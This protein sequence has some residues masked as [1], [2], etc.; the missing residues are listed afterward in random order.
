[1]KKKCYSAIFRKMQLGVLILYL[2]HAVGFAQTGVPITIKGK[3]TERNG[4]STVPGTSIK[5]KG[6]QGGTSSDANGNYSLTTKPGDILVFSSIGYESQEIAVTRQTTVNI[7]FIP[8]TEGLDEVVVVGFG[9]QKKVNLTG[10]V[11]S[12]SSKDLIVRPVGQASAALQGLAAGVTVT[13]SSGQPGADAG[14]IRIRGIGTLLDA[15]PL[16]LID[17]VEG[18]INALDPNIIENVSVLKD[19]ASASIYG[20]R[21]ANGVILV[22]TKRAKNNQL[23]VN[24]NGY[25]GFQD[26][27]NLPKMVNAIDH[28]VLTN[29]A[30]TNTGKAPLYSDALIQAYRDNPGNTDLYPNT[31]WQKEVLTGS[32]FMQSHFISIN[33]GGEKI[34]FLTSAG[35]FD[36][37]GII[38]NSG[39]RRFT[40]RNNADV[41]FSDKL[42]LKVDLQLLAANSL[43]PGP[44]TSAVFH[45]MNRIPANQAFRYSNGNWGEGWNGSNPVA[46]TT[47]DGGFQKNSSPSAQLNATLTYQPLKWLKADLTAAP[48]YSQ[49]EDNN[50]NRAVVTYKQDGTVAYTAPALSTLTRSLSHSYYNNYRATVTADQ[51]V[52]DH[53]FKVLVGASRED[54]RNDG[55]SAFRDNFVLPDYPVLNT[56]S[57]ANQQ[58]TGSAAEWALQSFFGRINYDYKQKYLLEINGRYDGSSRFAE[59]HKYGFFPSVSA[60]WRI[61]QESFMQPVKDVINDLKIRA[62]W[63][64]L[65]N[66]NI[67]NYPFTSSIASGSYTIG[68]QIVNIAALNTL[69]NSGISWETTAMTDFGLDFTI[70]KNLSFTGD[71]YIRRS[72]DILYTLDIPLTVGLAAPIQNVGVVTNK[73]Y[74]L[75][76]SYRNNI[77]DFKYDISV[78]F[79]DVINRVVDLRGV[80]RSALTVSREGSSINS[81]FGLQA[82]G[83]FQ[84]DAEAAAHATQF[85]ITKAGDIKY[86]DQNGDGVIN[87]ADNVIIGST[88][89]RYTYS[90]S[91]NASYK[92]FSIAAFFQ[93]VGKADGFLYQQ[94]IMPFFNGGTV[95]EQHKDNWTPTNTGAAFPRLAFSETNNEKVSSFWVKDASYLRLKNLQ[96][97][98]SLPARIA[99][100]LSTSSIRVFVNGQNLFTKDHFWKGYDVEAPVGRGDVYP[101]VKT[102]TVGL[103]VNF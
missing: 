72:R 11:S 31:D 51:A 58:T 67:G 23:S 100:K 98:Y 17:G 30:Y 48:R 8:S 18:S 33:G 55:F 74:E 40:L 76:L 86:K 52:G 6:Q 59:G 10:A 65:G 87:D 16:V 66:Q 3:I 82:E 61:S 35:F 79:S 50:F 25:S 53:T 34:R 19:A 73:G 101:Q 44:G 91:L 38:E 89:P 56:G 95:Q 28:M 1:M 70:L 88:I 68:K 102:Y 7:S 29:L 15:N 78:N 41:R 77:R 14:N 103:D 36:Q 62:S 84:S 12:I 13:Q 2:I 99:S 60:G 90:A 54:Y 69:A 43:E 27:T 5:I 37:K 85:G 63:G 92:G 20:S 83:L 49:S 93:G 94:G 46:F 45:W 75:A 57:S 64:E 97:G 26:P 80:N 71:Y 4:G 21:A 42:S 47:K 96:I 9:T 32:G 24:Y 81:L 39:F 22:T